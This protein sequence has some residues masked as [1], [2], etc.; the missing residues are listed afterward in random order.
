MHDHFSKKTKCFNS[1]FILRNNGLGDLLCTTPLFEAL[2]INYP[3]A[4]VYVGIG[5]WHQDILD[6]NPHIDEVIRI[7]APWHNQFTGSF[8]IIKVLRYLLFSTDVK[9]IAHLRISCGIDVVGSP[10]GSLLLLKGKIK[11]RIGVKGY[12]GGHSSCEKFIQFDP[13]THAGLASLNFLKVLPKKNSLLPN[14]NPKIYLTDQEIRN[15]KNQWKR[16][17]LKVIMAPGGSFSEKCWPFE[18]FLILAKEIIKQTNFQINIVGGAEDQNICK[19]ICDKVKGCKNL[20]NKTTLR[21]TFS[22]V[23]TSDILI[24]NSSVL[25]HVAGAFEINNLVLLGSWYD[26]AK[27]HQTQWGY[28]NSII[29]GKE[30]DENIIDLCTPM[31]AMEV[32]KK[33]QSLITSAKYK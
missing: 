33:L 9:R 7:N 19:R 1:F 30:S 15:A 14:H 22:L 18:N 27:L 5:N 29:L 32:V 21:E 12:A 6:G 24:S 2:K 13:Q 10:W 25:M 3:S 4:K 28:N 8:N 26:S 23:A 16:D 17:K 20:C 11:T 31:K